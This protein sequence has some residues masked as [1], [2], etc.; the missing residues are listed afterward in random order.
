M[1][2][3]KLPANGGERV[4]GL[5]AVVSHKYR[6]V[7]VPVPKSGSTTM[8]RVLRIIHGM[9]ESG[10]RIDTEQVVRYTVGRKPDGD[11]ETLLVPLADVERFT[12]E[13]KDYAWMSVV[14]NPYD[15]LVS[16]YN[17]DVRRYAKHFDRRTYLYAGLLKRAA[18][19]LGRDPR[20]TQ[21]N[22]IRQRIGFDAFVRGLDK[23]GTD[24]D[25]HFMRQADILFYDLVAYDRLIDVT[26]LASDLPPLL[27]DLGVE[28]DLVERLM[29][30]SRTNPSP[31]SAAQYDEARRELAYRL[32]Q[33]DFAMLRIDGV[34]PGGAR[35]APVIPAGPDR[36]DRRAEATPSV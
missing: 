23:Y 5:R 10:H 33:P 20:E 17:Y 2:S 24:F 4:F 16:M 25:I 36:A 13:L 31:P 12:N 30:L 19:V 8:D 1:T 28:K 32:Y 15:R 7:Y 26:R 9:D 11:L 14:R 18:F 29:P 21:R 3:A 35:H 22:T 6:F 34:G 27:A